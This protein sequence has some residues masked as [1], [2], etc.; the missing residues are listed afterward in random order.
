[1]QQRDD[2]NVYLK[3][4][5]D[6]PEKIGITYYPAYFSFLEYLNYLSPYYWF[7]PEVAGNTIHDASSYLMKGYG[8]LP[9]YLA[10]FMAWGLWLSIKKLHSSA[11][12]TLLIVLLIAPSAAA[13]V[14]S[15]NRALHGRL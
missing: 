14:L 5:L 6:H 13:I 3:I 12:Q 1:M 2:K 8:F 9:F 4:H 10:H 7:K 15:P 11:H